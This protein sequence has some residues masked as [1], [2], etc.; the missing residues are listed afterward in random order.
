ML[1]RD[2]PKWNLKV[3][4]WVLMTI[5]LLSS[6][7]VFFLSEYDLWLQLEMIVG[8]VSVTIFSFYW[9]VLYHGVRFYGYNQLRV[10]FVPFE[11]TEIGYEFGSIS[12]GADDPFGLV[13]GLILDLIAALVLSFILSLLLWIG[14]NGFINVV[15]LIAIPLFYVFRSSVLFVL[16][17][18]RDC[19]QDLVKSAKMAAFYSILKTI[20]FFI[21]IAGAHYLSFWY[22]EG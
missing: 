22:K 1:L 19:Y 18:S 11:V 10:T 8:L 7:G 21:V 16:R 13:L 2:R 4:F 12:S 6:A 3:T 15:V 17:N 5:L 9:W 14:L 20:W